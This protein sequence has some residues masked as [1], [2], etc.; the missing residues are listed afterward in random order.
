[1]KN[2]IIVR[3]TKIDWLGIID[4]AFKR[5][6]WGKTHTIYTCGDVTINCEMTKFE[7]NNAEATFKIKVNYTFEDINRDSETWAYYHIN[8]F[9]IEDFKGVITRKI[10][11]ELKDIQESELKSKARKIYCDNCYDNSDINED[12]ASAWGFGDVYC[13][14]NDLDVD[15]YMQGRLLEILY[16]E[17]LEKANEN[18]DELIDTYC[19]DNEVKIPNITK[20]LER[21][22]GVK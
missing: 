15:E 2:K 20:L 22:E 9:T 1:M 5:K 6:D 12:F 17:I 18:Y 16:E 10:I 14:I 11:S 8:N 13:K 21:L 4:L 3:E 7:F 19:R